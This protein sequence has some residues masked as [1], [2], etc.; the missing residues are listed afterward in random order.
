MFF[1]ATENSL[2]RFAQVPDNS[3]DVKVGK[4]IA[5]L[6]DKG[7]DWKNVEVPKSAEAPAASE[8]QAT[9]EKKTE[10]KPTETKAKAEEKPAEHA[11]Q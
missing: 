2:G 1:I 7:D 6:V 4:L 9:T 10:T 8:K 5:V 11:Q 3:T